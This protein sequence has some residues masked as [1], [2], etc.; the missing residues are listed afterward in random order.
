MTIG[1]LASFNHAEHVLRELEQA[2]PVGDRRVRA[3]DAL[4]DLTEAEP[5]LVDQERVSPRLL[6]RGELLA[7]DV[8]DD[9]EQ[10]RVAVV[11][12][13]DERR[14]RRPAGLLRS[15]PAALA[16]DQLEAARRARPHQH[17]LDDALSLDRVGERRRCLRI[18]PPPGLARIRMDRLDRQVC[19]LRFGRASD[20]DLEAAAQ[21]SAW[22]FSCG[23][24]A[25]SPP[26]SKRR[27]RPNGGGSDCR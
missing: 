6:D 18:E 12:L 27:R 23:R 7:R 14:D 22:L 10:E 16:C 11:G 25:P 13:S 5:E 4:A 3:A 24:Q 20:Q 9:A 2:D 17:R 1:Q 8:L 21:A 26:S 19:E 15:A